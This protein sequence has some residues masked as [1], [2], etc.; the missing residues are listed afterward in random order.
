MSILINKASEIMAAHARKQI[1]LSALVDVNYLEIN[2]GD[3]DWLQSMLSTKKEQLALMPTEYKSRTE[4]HDY[5]HT[6]ILF[7]LILALAV[8]QVCQYR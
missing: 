7:L 8:R 6:I 2:L 3:L 4:H 5:C 1:E